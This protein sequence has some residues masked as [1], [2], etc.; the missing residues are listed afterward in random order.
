MIHL[1]DSIHHEGHG[2]V[3]TYAGCDCDQCQA[4]AEYWDKETH[5]IAKEK[6]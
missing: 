6:N 4:D 1:G 3:P 2:T 5:Y